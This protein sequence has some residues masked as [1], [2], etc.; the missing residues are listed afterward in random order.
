LNIFISM[1]LPQS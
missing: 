1:W